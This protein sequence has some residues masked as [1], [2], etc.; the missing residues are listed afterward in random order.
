VPSSRSSVPAIGQ[1]NAGTLA[2]I[3]ELRASETTGYRKPTI[4]TSSF[5]THSFMSLENWPWTD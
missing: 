4:V 2:K 5:L 3:D 1:P